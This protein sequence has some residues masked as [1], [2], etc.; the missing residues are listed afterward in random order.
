MNTSLR[1][2]ALKIVHEAIRAVY[3]EAA[4]KEAL[5][6]FV[7]GKKIFVLA[8]GKA[9][10]RM[11]K[12]ASGSLEETVSRGMVITKYGYSL[13][14]IGGFEVWEAGHP[15]PDENTIEATERALSMVAD[16]GTDD[17]LLFLVSGGGSSLFELPATGVSLNDIVDVTDQLL[18]CGAAIQEINAVRKHLSKVKGGRF[19]QAVKPA[20]IFSLVLSDVLGDKLDTIASGPAYPDCSTSEDA[21]RVIQKY[22]ISL[23]PGALDALNLETPKSLDNIETRI[24][25][26][27]SI[28]CAA[29]GKTA[30]GLGYNAAI[31]TTTLDCQA[32]EAGAFLSA[33][34]RE[35]VLGDRPIKKPCAI[36]AGGE[37]VVQVRGSGLGGRNQEL[38]LSAARGIAGLG[39]VVIVSAATDGTDGPTDAAGGIVDGTTL[40]R[41]AEQGISAEEALDD[42][43]SYPALKAVGDLLI[44]GA[45]GT[46]VNDLMLVLCK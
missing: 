1:E 31:L 10:W 8:I 14:S 35:V 25:G 24:I 30:E 22:H 26:S 11:A 42:N 46:N 40:I 18:K 4:V 5:K 37:T 21:I 3:P 7:S 9:A 41:M 19:A 13:G 45:T 28:A 43:D 29:A 27:V 2:D 20:R 6:G 15:I 33:I 38:A 39:N 16:L 12:A 32:R 34:A 36:I 44:T 23:S 17:V